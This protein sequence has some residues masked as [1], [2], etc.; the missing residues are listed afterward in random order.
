[1]RNPIALFL[2]FS[3][4]LSS[5]NLHEKAVDLQIVEI[6]D[7]TGENLGATEAAE[8][9]GGK[10]ESHDLELL[11]VFEVVRHGARAPLI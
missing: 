3:L 7:D 8:A 6:Y 1:M 9:N 5:V 11:Q 10:E 2:L 4:Y